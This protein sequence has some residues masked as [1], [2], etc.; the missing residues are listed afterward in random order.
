MKK[1]LFA[2]SLMLFCTLAMADPVKVN[3]QC[4]N[5]EA[6]TKALSLSQDQVTAL[7]QQCNTVADLSANSEWTEKVKAIG[8]GIGIAVGSTA[9][10]LNVAANDF[11]R[12]PAGVI[13]VGIIVAKMFG[14]VIMK[15]IFLGIIWLIFTRLYLWFV[16]RIFD[17]KKEYAVTP[18]LFGLWQRKKILNVTYKNISDFEDGDYGMLALFSIA[19]L[20]VS[21]ICIVNMF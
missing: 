6:T 16:Q 4:A 10:Q 13:T 9:K 7:H 11:I 15:F 12:S 17:C 18:V 5:I 8:E 1:I 20:M 19:Y 3:D 14:A 21:V 2:L